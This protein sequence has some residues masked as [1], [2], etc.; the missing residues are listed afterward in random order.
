VKKIFFDLKSW[1]PLKNF[2]TRSSP[3]LGLGLSLNV[4]KRNENLWT[5]P[6]RIN[7]NLQLCI[8]AGHPNPNP[9]R[10]KDRRH[11]VARSQI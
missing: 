9:R 11:R 5:V 2:K 8:E 3:Y 4:K 10:Y 7:G 6:L 1:G